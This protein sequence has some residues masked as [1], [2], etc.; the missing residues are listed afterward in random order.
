MLNRLKGD[1]S[2]L[3]RVTFAVRGFF[4]PAAPSFLVAP[5]FKSS[6][7]NE[8][9]MGVARKSDVWKRFFRKSSGHIAR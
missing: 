8:K 4:A 9:R 3:L 2:R 7:R 1:E 6:G 5:K